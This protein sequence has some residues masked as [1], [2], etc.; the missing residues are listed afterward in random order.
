MRS[1]WKKR[2][3]LGKRM[4]SMR[5]KKRSIWKKMTSAKIIFTSP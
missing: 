2:E 1:V 5:K 4:G 3:L